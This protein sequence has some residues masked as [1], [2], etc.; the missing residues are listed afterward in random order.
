MAVAIES[1]CPVDDE[2]ILR[3]VADT[4]LPL[5]GL[6][7]HLTTAVVARDAGRIVGTAALELYG[8]GALLRS[9]AVAPDQRGHGLGQAVTRAAIGLAAERGAPAIYLLTDTAESFFPRLGFERITRAEVPAGVHTS[10]EFRSVCPAS[11]T[12]M[13]KLL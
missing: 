1:A 10:I 9:V 4:G 12:V 7:E 13:R 8:D 6:R 2:S 5:E 3:L 11:A